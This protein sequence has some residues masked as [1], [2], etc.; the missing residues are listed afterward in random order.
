MEEK[1]HD[2]V[3]EEVTTEKADTQ[4][5]E[6]NEAKHFTQEEVNTIVENRLKK[7]RKNMPTAEELTE[8]NKWKEE[9]KT[10]EEKAIELQKKYDAIDNENA[11]LKRTNQIL[12]KFVDKETIEKAD[13]I[14]YKLS[15]LEGDFEDNLNKYFEEK[16]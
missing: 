8:F 12:G 3:T 16:R 15:H 14:N 9:Q 4:T 10:S 6:E 1:K 11:S 7:E 5:A 2:V 13:Y